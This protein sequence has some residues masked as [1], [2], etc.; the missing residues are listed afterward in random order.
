MLQL[1]HV[2]LLKPIAGL[3]SMPISAALS[4]PLG[5]LC[6]EY[7]AEVCNMNPGFD[8]AGPIHIHLYV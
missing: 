7:E 3:F 5:L 1:V 8:G 2:V 4:T 6:G